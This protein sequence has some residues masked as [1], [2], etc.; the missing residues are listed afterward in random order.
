[1]K[2]RGISRSSGWHFRPRVRGLCQAC[3]TTTDV[4]NPNNSNLHSVNKSF[5]EK[6]EI[7]HKEIRQNALQLMRR[8][9]ITTEEYTM[10]LDADLKYEAGL[11]ISSIQLDVGSQ[12]TNSQKC[13]RAPVPRCLSPC[14]SPAATRAASICP[15]LDENVDPITFE[16]LGENIF[17]FVTPEGNSITYN[18]KS[19]VEY[20]SSSGDFRDPVTRLP[21]SPEDAANI[22]K[23]VAEVDSCQHLSTLKSI[24]ENAHFY[25]VEMQKME[26]CQNFETCLGEM[27][28][29]MLELVE[30]P[31]TGPKTSEVAEMRMYMLF[32]E[33]EAPF[34]LL[35]VLNIEKARHALLS[36]RVLLTGPAK[37]PTKAKGPPG[38]LKDALGFLDG[39]WTD[40]DAKK[41]MEFQ[42]KFEN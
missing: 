13:E 11:E 26:E 19:L 12:P 40:A 34:Q 30:T 32:S 36:W 24:R 6:E 1:M 41:L 10:V 38:I 37:R 8:G 35:K 15:P 14:P 7:N 21:L 25:C 3:V 22:D 18:V 31:T 33:F 42:A 39:Q 28:V 2:W 20:I 17:T 29:D 9:E 16:P 4:V 23:Q 27:I 5:L